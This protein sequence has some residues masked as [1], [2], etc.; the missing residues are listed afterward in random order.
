ISRP[1]G[2]LLQ[3]HLARDLKLGYTTIGPQKA[4]LRIRI[5]SLPVQDVLSRG[6]QKLLLFALRLAEGVLLYQQKQQRCIYLIDDLP[7]ELD[8]QHRSQVIDVL[9][10]IK[11]QTF[12]T[13]I[14][15]VDLDAILVGKEAKMFHVEHGGIA[16]IA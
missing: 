11:A 15:Q 9:T 8:Q 16:P 7:A 10:E 6:Q 14:A 13:G 3:E 1:L 12:I 2:E 5:R 4:D